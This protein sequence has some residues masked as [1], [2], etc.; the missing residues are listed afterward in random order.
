MA[1]VSYVNTNIPTKVSQC[2]IKQKIFWIQMILLEE[3]VDMYQIQRIWNS[4]ILAFNAHLVC[5]PWYS[6]ERSIRSDIL[7]H[8]ETYVMHTL[9]LFSCF[10]NLSQIKSRIGFLTSLFHSLLLPL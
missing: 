6:I 2:I 7:H 10:F 5:S 4:H 1:D 8:V 9:S 3:F